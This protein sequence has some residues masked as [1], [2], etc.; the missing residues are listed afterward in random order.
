MNTAKKQASKGITQFELT[1]N[2]INKL[3]QFKLT[4]TAKLVLIALS[5]YYNSKHA[6]IF[7]KQKT[8]AD[9][10]GVS[11]RTIV[12]AISE[13]VKEGLIIIECKYTNHYKFT[14]RI[15]SQC[16][17][18]LSDN[19]RQNDI[20]EDDNL[21]FENKKHDNIKNKAV[22]F[23]IEEE[24]KLREYAI[25]HKAKNI[26]AYVNWLKS[27]GKANEI[28]QEGYKMYPSLNDSKK[29]IEQVEDWETT[30]E[31]YANC[32]SWVE[33]GKKFKSM[34]STSSVWFVTYS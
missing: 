15:V 6:F 10:I 2:L 13:L 34:K 23:K 32:Q 25:S 17:E 19:I 7:P 18:N 1:N 21:S 31:S 26:N 5:T 20:K 24:K 30:R 9:K 29:I 33:L 4:P 14:Q 27:S 16:P 12:R 8:L 3:S 28:L 11:E 22:V